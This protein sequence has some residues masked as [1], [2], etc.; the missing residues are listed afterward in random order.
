LS[1]ALSRIFSKRAS[2]SKGVPKVS[3]WNK[4]LGNSNPSIFHDNRAPSPESKPPT[5]VNTTNYHINAD[6]YSQPSHPS[7]LLQSRR[8]GASQMVTNLIGSITGSSEKSLSIDSLACT[9]KLSRNKASSSISKSKTLAKEIDFTAN[10]NSDSII[11]SDQATT[12]NQAT[13]TTDLVSSSKMILPVKRSVKK[14]DHETK[15]SP[16]DS[17]DKI[18]G[19]SSN[20]T[21]KNDI[22]SPATLSESNSTG[23]TRDHTMKLSLS[24]LLP[25]SKEVPH[26]DSEKMLS[27]IIA[28]SLVEKDS[29]IS[30]HN[31]T[32]HQIRNTLTTIEDTKSGY[33][34]NAMIQSFHSRRVSVMDS[35]TG[36]PVEFVLFKNTTPKKKFQDI[37]DDLESEMEYGQLKIIKPPNASTKGIVVK[38]LEG[39]QIDSNLSKKKGFHRPSLP[40]DEDSKNVNF[41]FHERN[42]PNSHQKA[43]STAPAGSINTMLALSS[44]NIEKKNIDYEVGSLPIL[45]DEMPET[46]HVNH[47]EENSVKNGTTEINLPDSSKAKKIIPHKIKITT[48]GFPTTTSKGSSRNT[49]IIN[50]ETQGTFHW[51]ID[52]KLANMID[53]ASA[54]SSNIYRSSTSPEDPDI[55]NLPTTLMVSPSEVSP[56]GGKLSLFTDQGWFKLN[57]LL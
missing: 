36:E 35:S 30:T 7:P 32:M 39:F 44:Q 43:S 56:S 10:T 37:T 14:E 28:D 22:I 13:T 52:S 47:I 5:A 54:D 49:V 34:L 26:Q 3:L 20:F 23:L 25:I 33:Q 19:V 45:E 9:P 17:D 31:Q 16:V 41:D 53:G 40:N 55:E 6:I 2:S 50:G 42:T 48:T 27:S 38:G 24:S 15:N 57:Y 18:P 46:D 4:A 11:N 21:A 29:T 1:S 12:T 51:D 8:I